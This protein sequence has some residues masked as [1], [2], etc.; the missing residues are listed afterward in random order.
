[1][2]TAAALIDIERLERER[3]ALRSQFAQADPIRH[4]VIESFLDAGVAARAAAAFPDPAAM[5][6]AFAD[7]AEVKSAEQ[8]L[9]RLDPVFR[10]I[11]DDLAS[12][13]F[14]A[15]LQDVTGIPDLVCDPALHG[16]GLHQGADGSYLDIHADFNI[17]PGLGLYRRLNVLIYLN[18]T[19]QPE[20]QGYLELWS[21]DMGECRQRIA[22]SF[23]RC[24]IMETHDQAFHGYKELRLPAGVTRRSLAMYYYAGQMSPRQ[25][26]VA[27]DTI[28]HVRP[29]ERRATGVR[30]FL[31]R[32]TALAPAPARRVMRAIRRAVRLD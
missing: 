7:L 23:N 32:V 14:V 28:F 5:A 30:Q 11:F 2:D 3:D 29:G 18:T 17:H 21:R 26:S 13:R 16:G 22:P 8:R 12:P 10:A 6:I 31:R 24:V 25:T 20:W 15:W 27:H 1:M 9:D 4:V 19:W